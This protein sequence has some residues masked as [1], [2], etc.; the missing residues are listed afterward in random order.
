MGNSAYSFSRLQ[1][2]S[3]K[4]LLGESLNPFWRDL[5]PALDVLQHKRGSQLAVRVQKEKMLA[6]NFRS[7]RN[8]GLSTQIG[9]LEL[10][11]ECCVNHLD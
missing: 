8:H 3:V 4:A 11:D 7:S 9:S 1:L 6:S 2:C 5:G 10:N